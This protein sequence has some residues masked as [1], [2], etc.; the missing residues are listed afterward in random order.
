[1]H[2]IQVSQLF[3]LESKSISLDGLVEPLLAVCCDLNSMNLGSKELVHLFLES[4]RARE[5]SCSQPQKLPSFL[6][7][8]TKIVPC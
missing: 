1:M 2:I 6:F 3:T 7:T 8:A 4:C 5:E